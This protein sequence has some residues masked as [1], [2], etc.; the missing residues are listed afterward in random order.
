[1]AFGVV[2]PIAGTLSPASFVVLINGIPLPGIAKEGVTV[3]RPTTR[4]REFIEGVDGTAVALL[5]PVIKTTVKIR[6]LYGSAAD[7]VL[8][9]FSEVDSATGR[10][11]FVISVTDG[12]NPYI[13]FFASQGFIALIPD[14]GYNSEGVPARE[15]EVEVLN[16]NWAS[17]FAPVV[18]TPVG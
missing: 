4:K 13:T 5:R 3:D 1:M 15:W 7:Q 8:A 12:A 16:P 6:T 10:G 2:Q 17:A 9:G 11:G 14:T 18:P